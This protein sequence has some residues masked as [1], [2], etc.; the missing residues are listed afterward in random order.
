MVLHVLDALIA[1]YAGGPRFDPSFCESPG[2]L[3]LGTDPVA[4]DTVALDWLEHWRSQNNIDSM[5]KTARQHIDT[6]ASYGLGV[7]EKSKIKV[8][9]VP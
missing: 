1:Q 6:A 2:A 5:R 3:L 8:V 9:N 4:I 7:G